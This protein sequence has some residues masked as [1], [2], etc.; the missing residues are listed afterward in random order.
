VTQANN[1]TSVVDL[2]VFIRKDSFPSFTNFL[3]RDITTDVTSTIVIP[4]ASGRFYFG[5]YGFKGGDYTFTFS[6]A[7]AC[8]CVSP[9]NGQ[10][11][12]GSTT[13]QCYSGATTGFAGEFCNITYNKVASGQQIAKVNALGWYYYGIDVTSLPRLIVFELMLGGSGS[14]IHESDLYIATNR[15]PTTFDYDYLTPDN[16]QTHLQIQVSQ[17][18]SPATYYFG[19]HA[20]EISTFFVKATIY[21]MENSCMN[22]CSN[23]GS[24]TAGQ[25][26]C[27]SGFSGLS[28]EKMDNSL[29]LTQA[30]P[31]Y[32]DQ[33]AWNF[34]WIRV[35]TL[36]NLIVYI[37][38]KQPKGDC[39]L[40]IKK[41]NPPNFFNYDYADF[42][43]QLEYFVSIPNPGQSS[44]YFGV[45]GFAPCEFQIT[46]HEALTCSCGPSAHGS[47][48]FGS[49]V[50]TCQDGWGGPDCTD[51][52]IALESGVVKKALTVPR[53]EWKY[54]SLKV[55]KSIAVSVAVKETATIGY[56]WLFVGLK[57]NPSLI[58]NDS[59][60]RR[61][62]MYHQVDLVQEFTDTEI[63]FGVYGNPY[64]VGTLIPFEIVA[65]HA[66][67]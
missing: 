53:N 16:E 4:E 23:H 10:C 66:P 37:Q 8:K 25:C 41:E 33:G 61:I 12:P 27:Q 65:W 60:D 52:I 14:D 13:C 42:S 57:Q 28:C 7:S 9:S 32:V 19:V 48:A 22:N 34:F 46:A 18:T 56:V 15:L 20:R 63:R 43:T 31:G 67:F 44:W 36:N 62:S 3:A 58:S 35:N 39:D 6:L 5:I 45:Y 47:C 64:A 30:Q 49:T 40:Y 55:P 26:S 21:P 59:S 24:C 17:P 51:E 2:D 11:A 50:C 54:F 38:Q 29:T 1:D